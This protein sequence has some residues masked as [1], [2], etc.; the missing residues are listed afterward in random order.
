MLEKL[1]KLFQTEKDHKKS[2]NWSPTVS[3]REGES[4]GRWDITVCK[5]AINSLNK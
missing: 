2:T 3:L 1:N 4:G 5:I